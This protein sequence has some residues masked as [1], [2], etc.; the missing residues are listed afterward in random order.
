MR[1]GGLAWSLY[2][3]S[4]IALLDVVCFVPYMSRYQIAPRNRLCRR[5]SARNL[6]TDRRG[7]AG[8]CDANT[9]GVKSGLCCAWH[10]I[11]QQLTKSKIHVSLADK[12]AVMVEGKLTLCARSYPAGNVVI[13]FTLIICPLQIISKCAVWMIEVTGRG[14]ISAQ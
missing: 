8:G 11:D 7:G 5:C 9:L 14:V 12:P 3:A 6:P 10:N 4:P 1:T 2:L 13:W